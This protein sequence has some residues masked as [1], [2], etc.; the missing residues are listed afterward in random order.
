MKAAFFFHIIRK[1]RFPIRLV[2]L[3]LRRERN[4]VLKK[5]IALLISLVFIFFVLIV[6]KKENGFDKNQYSENYVLLTEVKEELQFSVYK[7]MDWEKLFSFYQKEYLT[8]E[9]AEKIIERLGMKEYIDLSAVK[10]NDAVSRQIWAEIYEK[11]IDYLDNEKQ[12]SQQQLFILD[13][14]ETADGSLIVTNEG[15]FFCTF[16]VSY[17]EKWQMYSFFV[18]DEKCV[19][20][21]KISDSEAVIANVYLKDIQKN[22]ISFLFSG[23]EY[24]TAAKK[25]DGVLTEG[26]CDLI[27]QKGELIRVRKKEQ[28][29]TGKLL[30]YDETTIEI[31]GYG[32]IAHTG[33]I[34][35][36]EQIQTDEKEEMTESSISKVV[37]GNRDIS[38]IIGEGEVCAIL[39]KQPA[40]IETIR[41]LLLCAD[42]TNF[43]KELYLKADSDID[44]TFQNTTSTY[45]K[46]KVLN[47]AEYSLSTE[48]TLILAPVSKTGKIY[49]CDASGTPSSNGYSGRIEVRKYEQGF[50]VVNDVPLETYLYA[51]VPSEMPSSYS[52]EAL[53]AQAVCARSY[54]YIQLMRADLA[55]Y[56]AHISDS[57]AYQVY[58]KTAPTEQSVQAVNDTAGEVIV[59]EGEVAEAYYFSTSAGYTETAEVWNLDDEKTYGYLK[60]VCLNETDY[61][62][63][64]EDETVLKQYLS[65]PQNGYDSSIKY[66]R[67]TAKADF[68]QKADEVAEILKNRH[69]I[70]PKNV[71]YYESDQTTET[72][73][74]DGFGKIQG[75]YAEKRSAS[76]SILTLKIVYENGVVRVKSEYNIRKVLAA[77]VLEIS[78]QD[79][80]TA[81]QLSLLPSAICT[82]EMQADQTY[83]L[84][85]GGFGHGLGMSQNGADG[86]AKAGYDYQAILNYFYQD[87]TIEKMWRKNE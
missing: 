23:A 61:A 5:K 18:L 38:Y 49:L 84:C 85:G 52:M 77:G 75:I 2:V 55:A 1:R 13:S 83:V 24:E 41:V 54:A 46:E 80:S 78:Y 11:I 71:L 40:V 60:R 58:N 68:R 81:S 69:S 9:A 10:E 45:E 16:P 17:F 39:M 63:S 19:G 33:K 35:V 48:D 53:K 30:S 66:Y 62:Q 22:K 67:W 20:I 56:G 76:G 31:D 7:E 50:T 14:M 37:L 12:V 51:V 43:R 79:K 72:A 73:S 87:I 27:F 4:C 47:A 64:L 28:T 8:K 25:I 57:T 70:S 15:D 29:V 82:V 65:T 86:L 32:R 36:Y 34:P 26:V 74:M 21:K 59:Y 42:G 3:A 6:Q 44:V